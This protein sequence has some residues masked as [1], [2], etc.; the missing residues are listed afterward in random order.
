MQGEKMSEPQTYQEVAD[1]QEL[2]IAAGDT[3]RLRMLADGEVPASDRIVVVAV[4]TL[5][6]IALG[7]PLE[8][9]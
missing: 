5:A 3:E 9:K 7:Q 6:R 2:F 8:G 1:L 4:Q